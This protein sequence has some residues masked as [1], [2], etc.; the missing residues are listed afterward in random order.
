MVRIAQLPTSCD[1]ERTQTG[2]L[3]HPS[4]KTLMVKDAHGA[5][6]HILRCIV[7]PATGC[8]AVVEKS[9]ARDTDSGATSECSEALQEPAI[10]PCARTD[11]LGTAHEHPGAF[12]GAASPVCLSKAQMP[13]PP[14][15]RVLS[16]A[17]PVELSGVTS[18]P[19]DDSADTSGNLPSDYPCGFN[20]D[21]GR[22]LK[23]E[24][25]DRTRE[26]KERKWDHMVG[27]TT[28]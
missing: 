28:G 2:K 12:A 23:L 14:T 18:V 27:V 4:L 22:T 13:P 8:E 10:D 15:S 19:L 16:P 26:C 17:C 20:L 5:L 21:V 6:V 7:E 11:G 3:S 9:A 25:W 1:L 24:Y